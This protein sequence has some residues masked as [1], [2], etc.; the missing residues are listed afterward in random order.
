MTR[1]LKS[2][3]CLIKSNRQYLSGISDVI[4][5]DYY[6]IAFKW[7]SIINITNNLIPDR[8]FFENILDPVC[9]IRALQA[10]EIH[11]HGIVADIGCGGG[12]L[13][14]FAKACGYADD[15]LFVDTDRK[16]INFCKEI[17]RQMKLTNTRAIVCPAEKLRKSSIGVAL[18]RAVWS[19]DDTIKAVT[20]ALVPKGY[21]VNFV[22][23]KFAT[24]FD[25]ADGQRIIN[26]NLGDTGIERSLIVTGF[27]SRH[28][29]R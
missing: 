22:S 14:Y 21:I 4:L 13:G 20:E 3:E 18:V 29:L 24:T 10:L 9:A 11:T 12:F 2:I 6:R 8:F 27:S 5:L 17:I 1:S 25:I 7:G 19:V 16:K 15:I 23:R 28:L 26:Y